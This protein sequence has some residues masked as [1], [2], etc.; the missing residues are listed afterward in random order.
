MRRGGLVRYRRFWGS[1]RAVVKDNQK[2][3]HADIREAFEQ[4]PGAAIH[5]ILD[6]DHGRVEKRTCHIITDMDW[7][8]SKDQW[9]GGKAIVEITSERTFKATAKK[10]TQVRH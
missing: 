6:V 5:T 1:Q 9:E 8:C 3:L 4:S 2:H 10:Q 7:V